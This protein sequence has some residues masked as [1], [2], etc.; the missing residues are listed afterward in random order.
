MLK[1]MGWSIQYS[2]LNV[3]VTS[4]GGL[5][6]I[7]FLWHALRMPLVEGACSIAVRATIRGE[8][9]AST[10]KVTNGSGIRTSDLFSG[11]RLIHFTIAGE[12]QMTSLEVFVW[13]WIVDEG[14][15]KC[16]SNFIYLS[17]TVTVP[18]FVI[19]FFNI[20]PPGRFVSSL[21]PMLHSSSLLLMSFQRGFLWKGKYVDCL[22]IVHALRLHY[23]HRF[24][25]EDEP[26]QHLLTSRNY[27][28][29][30]FD[31]ITDV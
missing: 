20:H 10:T 7:V 3:L 13:L 11:R 5:R 8:W 30:W 6:N 27:S 9:M 24:N 19:I 1:Q 23:Y 21:G 2:S 22:R 29:Y 26:S 25:C 14:L 12:D 4:F 17:V 31:L 15:Q 28:I 18:S 16:S